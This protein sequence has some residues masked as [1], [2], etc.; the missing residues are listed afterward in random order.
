MSNL[1]HI[2]AQPVSRRDWLRRC[3]T[4]F[5]ALALTDLLSQTGLLS[6]VARGSEAVN[7]LLAQARAAAGQSETGDSSVPQWRPVPCRHVRP[8]AGAGEIR[9]QADPRA[10]VDRTAHR[11]RVSLA[12]QIQQG[13]PERDRSQRDFS[14]LSPVDRRHVRRPLDAC[15]RAE[16][17]AVAAADELRR[18]AADSPQLRLLAH[19]WP[20][21]RKS[22][23]AR[24]HRHV[25][26]LSDPGIAELAS[27]LSARHLSGHVHQHAASRSRAS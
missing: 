21:D 6:A 24:L 9:R 10:F 15:R 25:P 11:R 1:P 12:L 7:P 5:G 27:R 3:G 4:G 16:S 26:G 2:N 20:G 14:A 19:V 8:Q 22:K 13:G 23:S 17:R 18:S